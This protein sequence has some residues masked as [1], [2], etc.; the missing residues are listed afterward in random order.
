M[1]TAVVREASRIKLTTLLQWLSPGHSRRECK[2]SPV[3]IPGGSA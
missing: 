3:G 2:R 1:H